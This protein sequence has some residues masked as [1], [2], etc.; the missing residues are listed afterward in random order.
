MTQV[1]ADIG[2]RHGLFTVRSTSR[3]HVGRVRAINEDRVFDDTAG[4]VWA[5]VDGMGGHSG[6]DLAAQPAVAHLRGAV[7]PP[8]PGT[9]RRIREARTAANTLIN[10]RNTRLGLDAGAT[11]VAATLADEVLEIIWAGDSRAYRLGDENLEPLTRDHSVVQQ[12]VDRG[13]LTPAM[14]DVHPH[15]NVVTRALGVDADLP[16]D[17]VS[18]RVMPGMEPRARFLLCSDGLS[19]SLRAEDSRPDLALDALA[20]RMIAN[21]LRRDGTDNASLVLIEVERRR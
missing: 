12:L 16:L 1:I 4:G 2:V 15:A 14:A 18:V 11:A 6:G 13:L 10:E 7:A 3:S 19:R 21:A 5:V 9:P 8:R 20:D 17:T